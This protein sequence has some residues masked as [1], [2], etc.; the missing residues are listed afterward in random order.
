M[1]QSKG[2]ALG[3][4]W[5]IRE[6]RVPDRLNGVEL[7][8]GVTVD[9]AVRFSL[10]RSTEFGFKHYAPLEVNMRTVFSIDIKV[11]IDT[12]DEATAQAMLE[13]MKNGAKELFGQFTIL[14][15]RRP[16]T[17]AVRT[18]DSMHG[19]KEVELFEVPKD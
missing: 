6:V 8:T 19:Q 16:P 18:T 12:G 10:L 7:L 17:V 11:D 2:V 15:G 9:G 3:G 14:A 13:V 4:P 5:A 1:V